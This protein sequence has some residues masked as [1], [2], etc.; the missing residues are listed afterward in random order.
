MDRLPNDLALIVVFPPILIQHAVNRKINLYEGP[1]LRPGIVGRITGWG[2]N[3][4]VG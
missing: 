2:C 1:P 4:I 3:R